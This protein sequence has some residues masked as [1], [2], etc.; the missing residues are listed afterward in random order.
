MKGLL[1]KDMT[2]IYV[3]DDAEKITDYEKAIDDVKLCFNKN[4]CSFIV[5]NE[6]DITVNGKI[7]GI[8]DVLETIPIDRRTPRNEILDQLILD[9]INMQMQ[10]DTLI[11]SAL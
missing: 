1:I 4:E 10:I 11:A 7:L 9:N 5:V 8:G 3:I 2:I 6:S